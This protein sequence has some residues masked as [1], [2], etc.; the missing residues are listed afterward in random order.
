MFGPA[1]VL[2]FELV[3][4]WIPLGVMLVAVLAI[5]YLTSRRRFGWGFQRQPDRVVVRSKPVLTEAEARFLRSLEEAV[6]GEYLVCPQLPLWTFIEAESS[7][8]GAAAVQN[9]RINLKRVD[10][11]LVDRRTGLVQKAIEL[12]DRTHQRRDRRSRDAFVE[13]VLN[14]A[15]VPLIRI[16]VAS[17]YDV[18]AV[19]R[20][21]G[22]ESQRVSGRA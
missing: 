16:P 3:K 13:G 21:L 6:D 10:F 18:A 2:P 11:C 4:Q 7:D 19:R 14:Q 5:T 9:N 17:A 22:L 1:I 8:P 15:K 12:D 20:Q